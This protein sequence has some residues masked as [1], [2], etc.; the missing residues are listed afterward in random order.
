M[1]IG[2]GGGEYKDLAKV[3]AEIP[4]IILNRTYSHL[5]TYVQARAAELTDEGKE[6]ARE[7]YAVGVGVALLILDQEVRKAGKAGRSPD[8]GA[9]DAGRQAAARAVLSVMPDYDRLAKELEE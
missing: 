3:D 2:H 5:K 1:A 6:Q 4:T 7:R 8:E 9:L